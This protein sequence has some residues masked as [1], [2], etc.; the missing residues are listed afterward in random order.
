[1]SATLPFAIHVT[2]NHSTCENDVVVLP[3]LY[4]VF[5]AMSFYCVTRD[6]STVG[7]DHAAQFTHGIL[8]VKGRCYYSSVGLFSLSDAAPPLLWKCRMY[9]LYLSASRLAR[10]L[11][12]FMLW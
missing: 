6:E 2:Q 3:Q 12:C 1:M 7:L 9:G 5:T 8:V 11:M 10:T 4:D